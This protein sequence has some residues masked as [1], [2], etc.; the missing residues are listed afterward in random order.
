MFCCPGTYWIHKKLQISNCKFKRLYGRVCRE[1]SDLEGPRD[2][3]RFPIRWK[4]DVI[5]LRYW[6]LYHPQK[7]KAGIFENLHVLKKSM[8]VSNVIMNFNKDD[9]IY[10]YL[11]RELP[12]DPA[13]HHP[14]GHIPRENRNSKQ[15]MHPNVH[16][17]TLFTIARTW[18]QPKYPSTEEW[19]KMTW[20]IYTMKHYLGIKKTKS[21]HFQQHGCT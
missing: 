20:Y 8:S 6:P 5:T 15:Y 17:S 18:K 13:I 3:F 4:I 1:Y 12:Y 21:C 11:K 7:W 10:I 2:L 9:Y 19:I 16:H 14:P